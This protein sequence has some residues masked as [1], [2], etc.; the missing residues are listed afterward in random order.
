M[1]TSQRAAVLPAAQAPAARPSPASP[2]GAPFKAE[3]VERHPEH[4][5]F[6]LWREHS[7]GEPGSEN[8]I[9]RFEPLS[10]IFG[11][12]GVPTSPRGFLICHK[13]I[14]PAWG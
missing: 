8:S 4:K 9:W 12:Q 13:S 14:A 11:G 2:H 7:L 6:S 1:P 3:T 10:A 5:A